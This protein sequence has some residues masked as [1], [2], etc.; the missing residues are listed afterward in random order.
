MIKFK[1]FTLKNLAK[2]KKYTAVSPLRCCDFSL[3]VMIMWDS[4]F[5]YEYIELDDT[6]ILKTYYGEEEWFFPPIGKNVEGAIK[7]IEKYC[8][9]YGKKLRFTCVDENLLNYY[10]TRYEGGVEYTYDRRWSDYYYLA[11]EM[12][13]FTGKKF[14]GQR[15]HINKFKKLYP[16]YK[17][18]KITPKIIPKLKE[19]L[20][21]YA[22]EHTGMVKVEKKEYESTFLLLDNFARSNFVGGYIT[23]NG[24]IASFTI[25]EIIGDTLDIHVEKALK[26]YQGVYPTTFNE[27]VK[28]NL[29]KGVV[30]VNREDDSGDEGLRTSKMQYHPAFISNKYYLEIKKPFNIKKF[31]NLNYGGLYFNKINE[32]DKTN[33]YRLYVNKKLNR[34]W[35]Y[36]YTKDFTAPQEND[37][38]NMVVSDYKN[39]S[40]CC[41]AIRKSKNGE[42][43]GEAVL[44]NFGYNNTVEIGVRFFKKYHGN[45]YGTLTF[46]AMAN[47]VVNTLKKIPVVKAYKQNVASNKAIVKS[48]FKLSGEDGKFYYYALKND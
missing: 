30:Y 7:E 6:L 35:G 40:N 33:Y 11:E 9:F 15:N 29:D 36:H 22:S 14:S 21:E 27:F 10:L 17:Y 4:S 20:L 41:L 38:Y 32:S 19:F 31:P 24:K 3:G 47:Y 44:H 16:N 5:S 8:A 45:G 23:I 25:A 13:T 43:I 37:F 18:R 48:G 39:K 34:Y 1:R 42:L 46:K 12:A 26:K 28:S 2:I